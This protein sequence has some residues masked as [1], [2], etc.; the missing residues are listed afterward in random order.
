ALVG[1]LAGSQAGVGVAEL[2]DPPGTSAL[3]AKATAAVA[4]GAVALL[5]VS[6]SGD[7]PRSQHGLATPH[8]P[9][10]ETRADT[11]ERATTVHGTGP[12]ARVQA[13]GEADTPLPG[14]DRTGPSEPHAVS[15]SVTRT[16]RSPSRVAP[17]QP[18]GPGRTRSEDDE[19]GGRE[20]HE[21]EKLDESAG[22]LD[23]ESWDDDDLDAGTA[24]PEDDGPAFAA[25]AAVPDP[26]DD[27]DDDAAEDTPAAANT[28]AE[29]ETVDDDLDDTSD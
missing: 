1:R 12:M 22:A 25:A 24:E 27:D 21:R 18:G 8:P 17:D 7:R 14:D 29:V 10:L 11:G 4:A 6:G 28:P 20:T 19:S 9:A 13:P 5:A 2:A 15:R 23:E 16:Q 26:S 3:L